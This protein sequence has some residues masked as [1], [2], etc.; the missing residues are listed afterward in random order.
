MS[1]KSFVKLLRKVIREEVKAAVKEILTEQK[2]DDKQVINHGMQMAE[3]SSNPR[4]TKKQYTKNS[5]LNDILNETAGLPSDGPIVSQGTT[6]YPSLGNFKSA[7]ADS[8]GA[9]RTP[10]NS[11]VTQGIN[12]EPI[13]MNNQAVASTVNAITKDYSGVMKAMKKLDKSKGKKVV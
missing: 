10:T 13:N 6:D 8:F 2:V 1:S 9:A 5:M 11:V 3:M 12:G 4:R 7:M